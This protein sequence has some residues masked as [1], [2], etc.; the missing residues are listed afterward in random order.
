MMNF[1]QGW[2][3]LGQ[4]EEGDVFGMLTVDPWQNK[5]ERPVE[6]VSDSVIVQFALVKRLDDWDDMSTLHLDFPPVHIQGHVGVD[7]ALTAAPLA[8]AF[9]VGVFLFV[10]VTPLNLV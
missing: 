9:D 4:V 7:L 8:V 6:I 5:L 10:A 3:F 2:E 1:K